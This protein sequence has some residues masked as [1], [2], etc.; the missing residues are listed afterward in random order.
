MIFSENR[1]PPRIKCGGKLFRDH[2]LVPLKTW[3]FTAARDVISTDVA[4]LLA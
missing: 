1:Y 4:R 2:A 3:V